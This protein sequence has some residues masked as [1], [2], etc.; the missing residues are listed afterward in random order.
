M[1]LPSIDDVFAPA[2]DSSFSLACSSSPYKLFPPLTALAS[3]PT[4]TS[5]LMASVQQRDVPRV[6]R[7][8][9][10]ISVFSA[11]KNNCPTAISSPKNAL[12]DPDNVAVVF[13]INA[14]RAGLAAVRNAFPPHWVHCLAIKSCPLTFVIQEVIGAGLGV[15]AASFVELYMAL[16]HGCSSK[17]A[18]F[19]SP[20]KT[21]EE[22]EMALHSGTLVNANSFEE[23]DRI[24]NILLKHS[25]VEAQERGLSN[26]RQIEGSA[27]TSITDN[28]RVGIRLNPLV[29]SGVLSE[30]STSVPNSKFGV[31]ISPQNI[32]ALIKAFERWPWIVGLHVHVGSQ[33]LALEKLGD[34]IAAICDIANTVDKALGKGR[35]ALIDIGGGL[36]VNYSSGEV[37]PTFADY[38][39]V[40]KSK[41]PELFS[42]MERTVI[43]EFGRA[44]VVK[45]AV[46]VSKVEYVRENVTPEAEGE[47]PQVTK[48]MDMDLPPPGSSD[49]QTL[50]THMGADLFLRTSYCP[51]RYG[52]RLSIYDKDG[53]PSTRPAIR[54]DVAGPLCFEGD[55]L[56]KESKLPRAVPGD[57][58]VAHDTGGNTFS[59]FSRHC[60]RRAP[61]V[62]GY[63]VGADGE[64]AMHMIKERE[65]VWDVARFWGC[66]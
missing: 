63:A 25:S 62:Y 66:R 49:R 23:L 4:E 29:G 50:V 38:A 40:L 22:L 54:T 3:A 8:L 48:A 45:A 27:S 31:P 19:D 21:Y 36:P 12:S 15:E 39:D 32:T 58:V 16:A 37:T 61:A 1:L 42:N 41:A 44:L 14:L 53:N 2:K 7:K 55:Y 65:S 24:H 34:G 5:S 64:L 43:T 57:L 30:L 56:A 60:S 28:A 10:E 26:G 35:V 46:T 47:E 52:H 59:M 11:D 13:D 6:L 33:S 51:G 18:V 20:A 17:L 9:S